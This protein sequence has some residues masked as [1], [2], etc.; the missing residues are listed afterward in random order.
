MGDDGKR[1]AAADLVWNIGHGGK[2]ELKTAYFNILPGR[3]RLPEKCAG[4]L[5]TTCCIRFQVAFRAID[6]Y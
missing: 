5:D 2:S 3:E 1:A 6:G 4:C